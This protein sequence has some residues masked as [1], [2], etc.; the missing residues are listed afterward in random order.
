MPS[1][2]QLQ[3]AIG[4]MVLV[5]AALLFATGITL[6]PSLLKPLSLAISI[7]YYLLVAFD[8]WLWR[9]PLVARLVH[10]PVLRGTWKGELE[11]TWIDPSS[12][13]RIDPVDVFLAV[14]QTYSS[15]SLRIMTSESSSRS[16]VASMDAPHDDVPRVSSTY[17]N[18][19]RLLI[20][21]RSR[22]HHGAL[23]L[24][25]EGVPP[26]RL[27]GFYWTD[28]DTKGEVLLRSRLP[29]VYTSFN[30]ASRAPWPSDATTP[31]ATEPG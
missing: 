16:L 26:T 18:I 19:P 12:G 14:R 4:I 15:V 27:A 31:T 5:W 2:S 7:A 29:K 20:Q 1:R 24:D 8:R 28:R 23:M 6:N 30:E 3:A 21:N 25:V 13:S 17:Q 22:I 9:L 11:S 10:R